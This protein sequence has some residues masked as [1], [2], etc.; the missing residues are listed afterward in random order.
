MRTAGFSCRL[1]C[2][3]LCVRGRYFAFLGTHCRW[4]L[5]LGIIGSVVQL[6][7]LIQK[8]RESF[9]VAG[10]AVVVAVWSSLF[11][12]HWKRRES[13][14]AM[15]VPQLWFLL[16]AQKCRNYALDL[17]RQLRALTTL[18]PGSLCA[19]GHVEL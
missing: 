11:T 14:L 13:E 12:E 16:G 9:V 3:C 2:V 7:V 1:E 19:V 17:L 6:T 18:R 10:F 8:R 5:L 15:K 4:L